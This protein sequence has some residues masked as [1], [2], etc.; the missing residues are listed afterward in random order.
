MQHLDW[1]ACHFCE[2]REYLAITKC[3]RIE[4][5]TAYLCIT[6]RNMLTCLLTVAL[7]SLHHRRWV[8]E[9]RIIRIN[10]TL[11]SRLLHGLCLQFRMRLRSVSPLLTTTLV[12]PHAADILQEACRTLYA[13]LICEIAIIRHLIYYSILRFDTH[14]RP[15]TA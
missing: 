15:C 13:T 10:K 2:I 12:E 4:Y 14:Q 1:E 3:Q 7:Y 5:A 8:C 6:L 11:E 9:H